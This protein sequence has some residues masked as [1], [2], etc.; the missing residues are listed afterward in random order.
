MEY[1]SALFGCFLRFTKLDGI[2]ELV[3]A[4]FW[5]WKCKDIMQ[6]AYHT[7]RN[8]SADWGGEI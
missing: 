6:S 3:N 8:V 7:R 2:V 1:Q 4:K 5:P